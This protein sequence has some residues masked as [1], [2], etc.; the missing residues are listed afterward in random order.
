MVNEYTDFEIFL[1]KVLQTVL[2][3]K[4]V[5]PDCWAG[6]VA[7]AFGAKALQRVASSLGGPA[8]V[9]LAGSGIGTAFGISGGLGVLGAIGAT[10][11]F[12]IAGAAAAAT[13]FAKCYRN[14]AHKKRSEELSERLRAAKFEFYEYADSTL[15]S[16][17]KKILIDKLYDNLVAA[18]RTSKR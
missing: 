5:D 15:A 3:Q 1:T 12:P 18:G 13:V 4:K 9:A 2:E 6:A 7:G 14:N 16:E 8:A 10:A 11:F 17:E